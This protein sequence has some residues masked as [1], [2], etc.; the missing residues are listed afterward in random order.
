MDTGRIEIYQVLNA[1]PATQARGQ[2]WLPIML[3]TQLRRKQHYDHYIGSSADY[4]NRTVVLPGPPQDTAQSIEWA[5]FDTA[6]SVPVISSSSSSRDT[7]NRSSPTGPLLPTMT[8]QSLPPPPAVHPV[9]TPPPPKKVIN[10]KKMIHRPAQ[11]KLS[12]LLQSQLQPQQR[13]TDAKILRSQIIMFG[14]DTLSEYMFDHYRVRILTVP[15]DIRAL[16]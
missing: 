11:K 12:Q 8:F 10:T 3:R 14:E 16:E 7:S 13:A 4:K 1:T 5:A 15:F 2:H 6:K 9:P